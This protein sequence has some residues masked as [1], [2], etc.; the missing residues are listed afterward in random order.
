MVYRNFRVI[1]LLH[2]ILIFC[3]TFGLAYVLLHFHF[4]FVPLSLAF[5][6]L[7]TIVS[8]IR[9]IE[10]RANDLTRFLLS[11]REGIF[12]DEA[13]GGRKQIPENLFSNTLNEITH[14]FAK[15]SMEKELHFQYLKTLNENI[16][17]GIISF[18]ADNTVRM[19]NPAAKTLL[20]IPVLTKFDDVKRV[21]GTLF[22][23]MST[24][25]PEQQESCQIV[26]QGEQINLSIHLKEMV[27][28]HDRVRIFLLL[29]V[30][31]ELDQKEIEAWQQLTRVLTHE[32]MNSITPITSLTKAIQSIIKN[33]DGTPKDISTL[34]K[35]NIEDIH[36]AVDTI[37][38]RSNGLIRFVRN[39]KAFTSSA[40]LKKEGADIVRILK[41]I[42]SLLQ[43]DIDAAHIKMTFI[44]SSPSILTRIDVPSIEQ[45]LINVIKNAME[46]V[47]GDGSGL[48]NVNV[49]TSGNT[50]Q[51]LISDNG[52]GI[53]PDTMSKIFVPF[54]T[55]KEKGSGIG[56]SLARQILKL[57]HG[58]IKVKSMPGN[59]STFHLEWES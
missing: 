41:R 14:E 56:L 27:L 57:H 19:V 43:P 39:Y 17:V 12:M 1:A 25:L 38:S 58:T 53:D 42:I 15:V 22:A 55:T 50:I 46:A 24:M 31:K 20:N 29:N 28:H 11:I 44:P 47:A 40:E 30:N 52:I 16:G 4:L 18:N 5:C 26:I 37:A 2:I 36:N 34:G 51:V 6:I 49:K 32:I 54:F 10:K 33:Q 21:D 23:V 9:F 3:F 48:I 45:V 59:G 13:M 7:A 8:L 35:E